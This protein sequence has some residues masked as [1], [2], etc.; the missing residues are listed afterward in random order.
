[1]REGE[2]EREWESERERE[3]GR[4]RERERG[5]EEV[6]QALSSFFLLPLPPLA[7]SSIWCQNKINPILDNAKIRAPTLSKSTYVSSSTSKIL[8]LHWKK[9]F[10]LKQKIICLQEFG[11][12]NKFLHFLRFLK[13]IWSGDNQIKKISLDFSCRCYYHNFMQ[14][15]S[16]V[17]SELN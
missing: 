16:V 12:Q 7:R 1:M 5:R 13:N 8:N 3:S 11:P 15:K 17:Q 2:R 4:E 9:N 14:N 6:Q 10:C